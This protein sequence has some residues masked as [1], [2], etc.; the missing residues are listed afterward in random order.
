MKQ[1]SGSEKV[2]GGVT[3]EAGVITHG[4]GVSLFLSS[5]IL[6]QVLVPPPVVPY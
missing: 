3:D 4:L 5:K 1:K 6:V 2:D